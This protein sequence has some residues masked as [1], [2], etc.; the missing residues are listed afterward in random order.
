MPVFLEISRCSVLFKKKNLKMDNIVRK[1]PPLPVYLCQEL[2][3]KS[4][5]KFIPANTEIL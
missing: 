3:D 4:I 5:R 2:L 1:L